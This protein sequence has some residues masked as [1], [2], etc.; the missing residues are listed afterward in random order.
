MQA[1]HIQNHISQAS[2]HIQNGILL[3]IDFH[4]L[5]DAGL[6]TI[7]DQYIIKIS[8]H[9]T[10]S[11]YQSFDGATIMLP[12]KN[13]RPSIEALIWHNRYVFRK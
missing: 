5:F 9:L 6:I 13:K 10:S 12:V 3:R 4:A 2:N 11:Y 8:K 1:A 7:D